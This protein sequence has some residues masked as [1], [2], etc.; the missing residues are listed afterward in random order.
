M[1]LPL[2]SAARL[3]PRTWC[4]NKYKWRVHRL[5]LPRLVAAVPIWGSHRWLI[6]R[7]KFIYP[8]TFYLCVTGGDTV[9][10]NITLHTCLWANDEVMMRVTCRGITERLS[11][12][13]LRVV[14]IIDVILCPDINVPLTHLCTPSILVIYMLLILRTSQSSHSGSS[15]ENSSSITI[16]WARN[17]C[18]ELKFLKSNITLYFFSFLARSLKSL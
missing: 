6:V 8:H 16:S 14:M 4:E 10:C 17:V 2:S 11:I 1:F 5:R 13:R 18:A 7:G 15:P 12:I 3:R 9:W